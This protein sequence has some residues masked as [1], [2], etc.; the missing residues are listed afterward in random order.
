MSQLNSTI[1]IKTGDGVEIAGDLY[2]TGDPDSPFI[3]LFHQAR[4]NRGEYLEI[5]PRLV[6]NGFS[7]LA[8]DQRYGGENW[9]MQN[10][11]AEKYGEN[12]TYI[13]ALPDLR[14]AVAW[15]KGES[16]SGKTIVWGSSYSAALVFLLAAEEREIRGILS[17]SPGEYFDDKDR[18]RRNASKLN[19]PI[20]ITGG[21]SEQE[22]AKGEMIYA[23]LTGE[24]K[25][26][27]RPKNGVHGS[28]TL[29]EN[30]N[31]DGYQENWDAVLQF[32]DRFKK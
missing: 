26:Y 9:G 5:A 24:H 10:L 16:Y 4:S 32:L 18:V 31:P 29:M 3:L 7:C 30:R 21:T 13:G 8:I 22:V 27:H 14:A 12:E 1:E 17:F 15:K 19:I 20:F 11:T 28:S 2:L 25:I 23:S 6:E